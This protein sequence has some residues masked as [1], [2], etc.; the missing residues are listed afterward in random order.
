MTQKTFSKFLRVATVLII[1][2]MV[3]PG[4]ASAKLGGVKRGAKIEPADSSIMMTYGS[5]NL[6]LLSSGGTI[7][8]G[9]AWCDPLNGT[10]LAHPWELH[11]RF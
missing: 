2:M 7:V 8:T 9:N 1:G 3:A 11:K 4:L 5:D 6:P 10:C